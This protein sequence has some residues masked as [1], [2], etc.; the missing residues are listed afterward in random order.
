MI[1]AYERDIWFKKYRVYAVPILWYEK[2]DYQIIR[3]Y[4]GIIK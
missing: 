3:L 4:K 1:L 2:N